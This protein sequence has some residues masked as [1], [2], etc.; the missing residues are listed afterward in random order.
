MGSQLALFAQPGA[1]Y[2]DGD[3]PA[4][5]D[6]PQPCGGCHV[7]RVIVARAWRG[8]VVVDLCAPCAAGE[9]ETRRARGQHVP[10]GFGWVK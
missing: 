8:G 2:Y 6:A 10:E 1:I 5:Y 3:A 9:I 7:V 4:I